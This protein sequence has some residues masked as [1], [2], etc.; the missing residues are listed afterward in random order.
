MNG[1]VVLAIFSIGWVAGL[2]TAFW[3]D[4]PEHDHDMRNVKSRLDHW[5]G[6]R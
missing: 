2:L 6:T 4:S 1:L 5:D 3:D